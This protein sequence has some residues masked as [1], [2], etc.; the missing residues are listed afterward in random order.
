MPFV[1]KKILDKGASHPVVARLQIQTAELLNPTSLIPRQRQAI[2]QAALN[3]S[4]RLIRC[5]DIAEQLRAECAK[6][7]AE[8]DAQD[9]PQAAHMPHVI[10]LEQKVE[11]FLYEAKNFLRDVTGIVN[12]AFATTFNEASQFTTG[13]TSKAKITQW[14]EVTF[15]PHDRFTEFFRLHEKWIGEVV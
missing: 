12:A 8:H 6:A 13:T 2:M 9:I 3:A 7:E 4:L 10:G 15:G 1:F 14:A 11:T 5:Y